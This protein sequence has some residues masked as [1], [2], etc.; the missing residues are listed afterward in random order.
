M[1][2]VL[3]LSACTLPVLIS[4]GLK[5]GYVDPMIDALRGNPT[6][7]E[8]RL[9]GDRAIEPQEIATLGNL[10]GIG[11]LEPTT[12]S[13]S[14]RAFASNLDR[15]R[16]ETATLVPSS[17]GDP[18]LD[19]VPPPSHEQAYVSA[20]LARQLELRPG[21]TFPLYTS[22]STA[23]YDLELL[24]EVAGII[25][26]EVV[27][28]RKVFLAPAL[29]YGVE[30]FLEGY[31]VPGLGVSGTP[32]PVGQR[33][34]ANAR[35]FADGIEMVAPLQAALEERGYYVDTNAASISFVLSMSRAATFLTGFFGVILAIGSAFCLWSCLNM[36]FTPQRRHI[37]LFLLMGGQ[38][39]DVIGYVLVQVIGIYISTIFTLTLAFLSVST[40]LDR[41]WSQVD[42]ING[43][44]THLSIQQLFVAF[45]LLL[46][47][48]SLIGL[49]FSFKVFCKFPASVLR[50][51]S[52]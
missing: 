42:L 4:W 49:F 26:V 37:A 24:L 14:L 15:S 41:I 22:R 46:G 8:V 52:F 9:R 50:N 47:M 16:E 31:E 32:R 35:V 40:L 36:S 19:G 18:L 45:F 38:L 17:E 48:V 10:P 13:L 5:T 28:A 23:P 29:T 2:A 30:D 25:P 6:V 3:A 7:L 20:R 1:L 21:D 27:S 11:Y 12:R 51:E 33:T 44:D 43:G 34:F 39:K